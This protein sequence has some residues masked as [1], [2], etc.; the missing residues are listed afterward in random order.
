V[1]FRA[2]DYLGRLSSFVLTA[3]NDSAA[4]AR[5]RERGKR[6][7]AAVADYLVSQGCTIV[8]T[9]LKVGRLELDVV[10]REARVILVVEVRTRGETAW[11]TG[12]GSLDAAKRKRV[13]RAA[14]RLWQKRYR[15]D[16][17]IDRLRIDAASVTFVEGEPV[18]EYARAAF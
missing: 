7:E 6:A 5:A 17:T 16:P 1:Y 8:A 2:K 12:F 3:A 15:S 11:T 4:A 13:R 14:E 18:I 9:N 10:A